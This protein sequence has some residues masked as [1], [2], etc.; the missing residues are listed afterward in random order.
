M[1]PV[2]TPLPE[3][4]E[5]RVE[6]TA[7]PDSARTVQID[8]EAS[9]IS[10]SALLVRIKL[11]RTTIE[12]LMRPHLQRIV[13]VHRALLEDRRQLEAPLAS[14][15]MI[16]KRRLAAF[17]LAEEERRVIDAR[18]QMAAV[19]EARSTRVWAEVEALDTAGSHEEAADLVAEFVHT[20]APIVM[21]TPPRLKAQ[22]ITCREVWR[23]EVVDAARVPREYL[24]IDHGKLGSVVR[25]L[26]SAADIPGVRIWPE[27]TIATT[28]R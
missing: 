16:L 14:A 9:F 20:P 21:V 2:L 19:E 17:T 11:L 13:R 22:G 10:A 8:D 18:R 7:L 26:K 3:L 24:T 28:G 1:D 27:R 25:A 12:R 15:E 6:I 23:Y 4:S 5:I